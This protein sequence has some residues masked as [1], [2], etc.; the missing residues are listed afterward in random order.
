MITYI[1]D[2]W[3]RSGPSSCLWVKYHSFRRSFLDAP[4]PILLPLFFNL[5]RQYVLAVT[6]SRV[7]VLLKFTLPL[8]FSLYLHLNRNLRSVV[9]WMPTTKNLRRFSP[10]ASE[11]DL[12][13]NKMCLPRLRLR[14]FWYRRAQIKVSILLKLLWHLYAS[15]T[16]SI[17][18]TLQFCDSNLALLVHLSYLFQLKDLALDIYLRRVP[19]LVCLRVQAVI[20]Q[21]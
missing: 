9:L 5:L 2:S 18:L 14:S 13:W 19:L 6:F 7:I 17:I 15:N 1:V 10:V 21:A 20:V 3:L 12:L 16:M 11:R 8:G 4:L